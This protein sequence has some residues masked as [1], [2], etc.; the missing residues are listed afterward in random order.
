METHVAIVG[1]YGSA[2]VAAVEGL[3]DDPDVRL[4]TKTAR[5][6]GRSVNRTVIK[7]DSNDITRGVLGELSVLCRTVSA[8]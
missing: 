4:V 3:V 6:T 5:E 1:A 8:Y 2:G 7:A